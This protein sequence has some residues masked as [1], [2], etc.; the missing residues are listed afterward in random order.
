MQYMF[1][2]TYAYYISSISTIIYFVLSIKKT[3][4]IL[5]AQFILNPTLKFR[6]SDAVRIQNYICVLHQ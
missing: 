3:H 6:V 2:I 4:Y 5:Q 1:R